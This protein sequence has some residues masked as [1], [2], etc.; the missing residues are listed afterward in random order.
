LRLLRKQGRY[1]IAGAIAG[2]V[3]QLDLRRVYLKH[4]EIIGS[5]LGTHSEFA[6]LVRAIEAG[7]LQPV[8]AATYPLE[9]LSQAQQDFQAKGFFGK[10]VIEVER[11]ERQGRIVAG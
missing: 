11:A 3:I 4:L 10:L 7:R 6:A 9:K 8:L 2:P 1:V 5:T